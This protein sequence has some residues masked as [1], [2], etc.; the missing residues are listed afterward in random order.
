MSVRVRV[1]VGRVGEEACHLLD[2]GLAG[3]VVEVVAEDEPRH[4]GREEEEVE[5]LDRVR[6]RVG[7]GFGFG[8][9]FG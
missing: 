5:H 6:V 3:V 7:L 9:G 2:E 1:R 8:F 4:H